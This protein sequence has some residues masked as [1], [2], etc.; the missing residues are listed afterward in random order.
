M[1]F[2]LQMPKLSGPKRRKEKQH[3]RSIYRNL[4]YETG[5]VETW[6]ELRVIGS[7]AVHRKQI[8]GPGAAEEDESAIVMQDAED[9]DYYIAQFN[10]Q[11]RQQLREAS[12]IDRDGDNDSISTNVSTLSQLVKSRK[13]RLVFFRILFIISCLLLWLIFL[14]AQVTW[15]YIYNIWPI[16]FVEE[17]ERKRIYVRF[18]T[19]EAKWIVFALNMH[20]W[21]VGCFGLLCSFCFRERPAILKQFILRVPIVL[22]I[23][24]FFVFMAVL[25]TGTVSTKELNDAMDSAISRFYISTDPEQIEKARKNWNQ[26]QHLLLCCGV[27]AAS[28]WDSVDD[29][30]T[31]GYSYIPQSCCPRE[32]VRRTWKG[33]RR[34]PDDCYNKISKDNSSNI[35]RSQLEWTYPDGCLNLTQEFYVKMGAYLV[36]IMVFDFIGLCINLAFGKQYY[37]ILIKNVNM[38]F[39]YSWRQYIEEILFLSPVIKY[40]REKFCKNKGKRASQRKTS[41]K[42]FVS[43]VT[44]KESTTDRVPSVVITAPKDARVARM[45]TLAQSQVEEKKEQSLPDM[46]KNESM[47]STTGTPPAVPSVTFSDIAMPPVSASLTVVDETKEKKD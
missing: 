27:Q 3:H 24:T 19:H 11:Y 23:P 10:D 14:A 8:G 6:N 33:V 34:I 40:C 46:T 36:G 41:K 4:S 25:F 20:P 16:G 21:M 26:V 2:R 42:S 43:I 37:T 29:D 5:T 38:G 39:K 13:R 7:E 32:F 22:F 15:F 1:K 18:F 35:P 47:T 45:E 30:L 17:T 9:W 44:S 28:D 31:D 12:K